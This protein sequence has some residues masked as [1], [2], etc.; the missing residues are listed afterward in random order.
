MMYVRSS[1]CMWCTKQ[2]KKVFSIDILSSQYRTTI[3]NAIYERWNQRT[4]VF[5][6]VSKYLMFLAR[7]I[8]TSASSVSGMTN[9]HI[10]KHILSYRIYQNLHVTKYHAYQYMYILNAFQVPFQEYCI[11]YCI[12]YERKIALLYNGGIVQLANIFIPFVFL[13]NQSP[14]PRCYILS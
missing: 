1:E 10:H 12:L 4:V 11:V 9:S 3:H 13:P 14:S 8:V 5:E 2:K 6:H 7:S